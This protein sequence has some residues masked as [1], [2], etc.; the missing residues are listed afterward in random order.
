MKYEPNWTSVEA[1]KKDVEVA[2]L[3]RVSGGKGSYRTQR[4]RLCCYYYCQ[5]QE[6]SI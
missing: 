5:F 3:A 6:C 4:R 1:A 2:S